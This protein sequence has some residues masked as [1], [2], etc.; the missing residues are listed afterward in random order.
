MSDKEIT[1]SGDVT[2]TIRIPEGTAITPSALDE[3]AERVLRNG[4]L[5]GGVSGTLQLVDW[6]LIEAID[7]EGE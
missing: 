3:M 4:E 5:P 6:Y 2:V 7:V 1:L